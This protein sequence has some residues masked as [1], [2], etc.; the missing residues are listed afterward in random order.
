M[1]HNDITLETIYSI[2]K[3]CVRR[4]P[5]TPGRQCKQ[6]QTFRVLQLDHGAELLTNAMGA[7]FADK[8]TPYFYSR[9]WERQKHTPNNMT[10]E[11]PV[12][13]A[14]ELASDIPNAFK[15][16]GFSEQDFRGWKTTR[17]MQINRLSDMGVLDPKLRKIL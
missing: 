3:D 5:E 12:L 14:F 6:P 2:L 8:D 15:D 9:S 10:A 13:T 11:Y 7:K 1:T 4:Y 17:L 16:I